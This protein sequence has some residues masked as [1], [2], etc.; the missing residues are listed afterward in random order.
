MAPATWRPLYLQ[1]G[2]Y[3]QLSVPRKTLRRHITRILA[4]SGDRGLVVFDDKTHRPASQ[5]RASLKLTCHLVHAKF[6]GQFSAC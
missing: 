2:R 4:I 3:R 1:D 5:A 6:I